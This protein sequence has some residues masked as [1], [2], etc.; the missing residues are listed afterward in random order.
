MYLICGMFELYGNNIL[1]TY[2]FPNI[3]KVGR[4]LKDILLL[5]CLIALRFPFCSVLQDEEAT[6]SR[7]YVV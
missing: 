5:F 4:E 1:F 2:L 6:S 7:K 3:D